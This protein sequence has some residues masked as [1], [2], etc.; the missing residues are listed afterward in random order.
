LGEHARQAGSLVA[1]D[2][3]RFD[4]TH[5]EAIPADVLEAIEFDVN[6]DILENHKLSIVE[7]SL[8]QAMDEGAMALFG[9]KYGEKVRTVTVDPEAPISYELCGGTHVAQTGDIGTFLI[10]SEGSAAAGIRRIEAV[11]GHKA[12]EVIRER[13]K[14]LKKTAH[15]LNVPTEDVPT[16]VM[17]LNDNLEELRK[18]LSKVRQSSAADEFTQKLTNVPLINGVPVLTTIVKN[19]DMDSLRQMCDHFREKY[20][21]GVVTV[22]SLINEKPM[23]ICAVTDDLVKRGLN[24]GD[25]VRSAAGVMGGSGGGRPNLAQ[26]GGKDPAKLSEAIDLAAAAIQK[27]LK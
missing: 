27:L 18:E 13:S 10:L 16:K 12:Y 22:G 14:A 4:F 15:E 24:A 3:L 25:I 2:R 5:P 11:T 26:A 7:K 19:A 9:E 21:S 23:I 8:K 1:P 20:P 17:L 6:Q